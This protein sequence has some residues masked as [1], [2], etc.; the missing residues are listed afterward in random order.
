MDNNRSYGV[1]AAAEDDDDYGHGDY[2]VDYNNAGD[3]SAI[4]Y[5]DDDGDDDDDIYEYTE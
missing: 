4:D 1:V 5:D 2:S 3:Y